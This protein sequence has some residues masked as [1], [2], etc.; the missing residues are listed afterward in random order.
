MI[1]TN[2]GVT[3]HHQ[4]CLIVWSVV[5][6]WPEPHGTGPPDFRQMLKATIIEQVLKNEEDY[7]K[8]R[9]HKLENAKFLPDLSAGYF[10]QQIDGVKNF[11]GFE[12]GLKIPL[13]F[14]S[15]QGKSQAAKKSA[16]IASINYQQTKLELDAIVQTKL[17]EYEKQKA[18][19]AYYNSTGILL[20]DK[21]FSSAIKAYKEG[22]IGYVEYIA[23]MEQS[24]EIRSGYLNALNLHNQTVNEINYLTGKYN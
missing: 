3:P 21:L 10:N 24:I 15:Q 13:F 18:A 9:E 20:A 22:E 23:L 12:V 14:R 19:L 6:S 2:N 1:S 17:N 11:S 16:E 7:R 5:P 8:E 4:G